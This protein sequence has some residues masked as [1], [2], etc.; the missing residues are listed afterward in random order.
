MVN[1]NLALTSISNS[2]SSIDQMSHQIA[3]AAEEQSFMAIEIEKN[4]SAIAKITD[5]TQQQI[6]TA[7]HLNQEMANL[8]KKQL[9]LITRFN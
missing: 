1:V 4:T 8:S 9:D 2:V 3:T 7:D 6:Q 5:Q